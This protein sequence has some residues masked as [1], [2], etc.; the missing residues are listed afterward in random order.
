MV[1]YLAVRGPWP[2]PLFLYCLPRG[3][4][5]RFLGRWERLTLLKCL[6]LLPRFA[7]ND[8]AESGAWL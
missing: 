5:L 8:W 6:G 7:A 4:V 1:G 3:K 2:G